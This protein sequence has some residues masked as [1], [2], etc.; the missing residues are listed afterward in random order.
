[1][2]Y[3]QEEKE[4]DVM[5]SWS[6]STTRDKSRVLLDDDFLNLLFLLLASA[7]ICILPSMGGWPPGVSTSLWIQVRERDTGRQR[8][9]QSAV[10]VI[11]E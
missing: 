10:A 5:I 2:L 7:G 1:M 8:S 11:K 4:S 6:D 3:A 9:S